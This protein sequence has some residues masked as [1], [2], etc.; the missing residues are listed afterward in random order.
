MLPR[1]VAKYLKGASTTDITIAL[2]SARQRGEQDMRE[3]A[4]KVAARNGWH[5]TATAIRELSVSDGA[6]QNN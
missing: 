2:I 6:L 3:R 5:D 1:D 4:A